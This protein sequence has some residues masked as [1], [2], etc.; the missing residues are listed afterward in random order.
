MHSETWQASRLVPDR[1]DECSECSA[2]RIEIGRAVALAVVSL[3]RSLI[4]SVNHDGRSEVGPLPN[5]T[6]AAPLRVLIAWHTVG[7]SS[8]GA[9]EAKQRSWGPY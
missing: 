9:F 7:S 8:A 1:P 4:R 6:S 2:S 5:E 3:S